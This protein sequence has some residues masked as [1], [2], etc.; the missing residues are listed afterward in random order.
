MMNE[1]FSG[2]EGV[3]DSYFSLW[4]TVGRISAGTLRGYGI[5]A[6]IAP[7]NKDVLPSLVNTDSTVPPALFRKEWSILQPVWSSWQAQ[8]M[9]F[10]GAI[11]SK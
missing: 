2:V 3:P 6:A 8:D 9:D 10:T 7:Q 5:Y 1:I 4:M 11:H